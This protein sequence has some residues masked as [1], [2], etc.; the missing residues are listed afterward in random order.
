MARSG[1]WLVAAAVSVALAGSAR[2]KHDLP[3]MTCEEFLALGDEL[4]PR[5]VAWLDGYSKGGKLKEEDIGEIDV[6]R[7]TEVLIASCKE[8]PKK[9]LWET[10]ES[11]LPGGKK[12]VKPVSMTCEEFVALSKSER[13]ELYYW[14]KGYNRGS[15][16]KENVSGEVDLEKDTVVLYEE[17]RRT[18]K[19]SFWS[20]VRKHF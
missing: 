20:R 17:C 3:K 5:A 13:P 19:A 12:R 15:K 14:A 8:Q 2:A 18:P 6:H 4:Q 10:I 1:W 9:S 16:T 7:E 11:K